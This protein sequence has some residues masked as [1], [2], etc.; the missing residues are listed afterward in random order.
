LLGDNDLGSS[1]LS[2]IAGFH[3]LT[4]LNLQ[5]NRITDIGFIEGLTK[6][7]T[8][9]LHWDNLPENNNDIADITPL[10]GLTALIELNLSGNISLT[11]IDALAGLV[12]LEALD[13]PGCRVVDVTPLMTNH[14]S[15][16]L[17]SG[18][19]VDITSNDMDLAAGSDNLAI[20]D[21]LILVG[22]V[23]EYVEGNTLRGEPALLSTDGILTG[24]QTV[25]DA[26]RRGSP[27]E[28]P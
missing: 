21:A 23:V 15:G 12:N 9:A 10:A 25:S 6:L 27:E 22:V 17:Q 20:V 5:G 4:D 11:D 13:L 28:R 26:A 2:V 3:D 18:S 7:E 24:G 14:N 8:L 1:D 19:R 16:G